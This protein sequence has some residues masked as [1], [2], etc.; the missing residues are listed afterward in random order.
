V[1]CKTFINQSRCSK[2]EAVGQL[3]DDVHWMNFPVRR[4][5]FDFPSVLLVGRHEGQLEPVEICSG[6][7]IGSLFDV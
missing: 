6:C 4:Q 2:G 7:F 5:C 3:M 1:G